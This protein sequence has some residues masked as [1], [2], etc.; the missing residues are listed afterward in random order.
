M[1]KYFTWLTLCVVSP[2]SLPITPD[3]WKDE[4][5]TPSQPTI[6]LFHTKWCHY[7]REFL[8]LWQEVVNTY[9]ND[10]RIRFVTMHCDEKSVRKIC[11]A[12]NITGFPTIDTLYPDKKPER[13][14]KQRT[15]A[16]FSKYVD[17]VVVQ[18]GP[19]T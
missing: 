5:M 4:L 12:F 1:Y 9:T 11:D 15:R 7:C 13:Y 19:R 2:M 3:K 18:R 17:N 8:P 14:L 16:E 10:D 6:V